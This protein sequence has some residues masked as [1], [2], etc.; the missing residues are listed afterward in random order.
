[1]KPARDCV[2]FI[3]K[4]VGSTFTTFPFYQVYFQSRKLPVFAVF[5]KDNL[6]VR[7][8][9]AFFLFSQSMSSQAGWFDFL[10]V[11]WSVT[12]SNEIKDIETSKDKQARI[13]I[14]AGCKLT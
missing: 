7:K 11:H 4:K 6:A 12:M 10:E 8:E 9:K 1:M 3:M 2:V 5:I 14:R 13:N